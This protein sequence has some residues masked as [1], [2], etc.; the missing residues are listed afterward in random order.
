MEIDKVYTTFKEGW[1]QK[2]GEHIKT[3]RPRYFILRNDGY[4]IGYNS[5]PQNHESLSSPNNSFYIKD[6]KLLTSDKPK[7]NVFILR[8]LN[9]DRCFTIERCFS[10][11]S[12]QERDEWIKALQDVSHLLS[13]SFVI[14]VSGNLRTKIT[15]HDFEFLKILGKGTFG[16]V[17]LCRERNTK[18]ICAMKILKK[19]LIVAKNEVQHTQTENKVLRSIKHPF[20]TSLIYAFQTTDRLCLV[21]EYVNGG[22][23]FFHLTREKRFTEERAKFY[24]AE[25]CLAIGFLH[26]NNIIY[27]DIKLENIL[28]DNEGH[29]KLVDF[30]LCKM[31]MTIDS[32][33]DT[34]CGTPEYLA[35]EILTESNGNGYNRSV[36]WWAVGVLLYEMLIGRLPFANTDVKILFQKIINDK[37]EI[38]MF[39]SPEAR[40]ILVQLLEKDPIRRLGASMLDYKE[41]QWHRFFSNLN[42]NFLLLKQV[43]PP[44]KPLV[45]SEVDTRYFEREFTGEPV[46]LTPTNS[47]DMDFSDYRTNFKNVNGSGSISLQTNQKYFDSFSYYGS[48]TSLDKR[49]RFDSGSS[50]DKQNDTQ[51]NLIAMIDNDRSETSLNS[52]DEQ[53]HTF[54][55]NNTSN[56]SSSLNHNNLF[57]PYMVQITDITGQTYESET[58]AVNGNSMTTAHSI[59]SIDS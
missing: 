57:Y 48:K 45:E 10:A 34:F 19:S 20:I 5:K 40:S 39:L 23:L 9:S 26:D 44:F 18:R 36:D 46:Q 7:N 16:K 55:A 51:S 52:I 13:G 8:C 35:P 3:W 56:Q 4:F 29:V 27:R 54:I 1:L 33:T 47:E 53:Q 31:D 22:E 32:T 28:L 41:L 50:G 2:R 21:M 6:C 49:Q 15:L 42:W 17:I 38:P 25:V 11:T 58:Y 24:T 12:P 59:D 14:D 43:E 37:A 30:G